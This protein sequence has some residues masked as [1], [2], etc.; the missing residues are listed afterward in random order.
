MAVTSSIDKIITYMILAM[1]LLGMVETTQFSAMDSPWYKEMFSGVQNGDLSKLIDLAK[2]GFGWSTITPT[3]HVSSMPIYLQWYGWY[4]SLFIPEGYMPMP[5]VEITV[6][7]FADF[8]LLILPLALYTKSQIKRKMH[9]EMT[10]LG[11][12]WWFYLSIPVSLLL[13][14]P[15]WIWFNLMLFEYGFAGFFNSTTE[16]ARAIWLSVGQQTEKFSVFFVLMS[17]LGIYKT[18][19][20]SKK[21]KIGF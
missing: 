4:Y 2:M 8:L 16:N 6:F 11:L 10:V 18:A 14:Y 15:F 21:G 7:I 13:L 19:V 20:W 3:I 12:P 1:F 17:V 9:G 5:G